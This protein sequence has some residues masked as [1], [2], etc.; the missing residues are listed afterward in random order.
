MSTLSGR[1]EKPFLDKLKDFSGKAP[2]FPLPNVVFY[3]KTFL[4]LHVFEPRYRTM[5]ADVEKTERLI[6]IVLLHPDSGPKD[7]GP[8]TP[9]RPPVYTMGTLGYMDFK[10]T[11]DDGTSDILLVGLAKAAIKEI[12]SDKPYRIGELA[13]VTDGLGDSDIRALQKKIFHQFE[14]LANDERI[15]SLSRYL[16]EGL[17]FEMAVNFIAAHTPMQMKEKQ[18]LLE[19]NDLSLRA[20]VLLQFLESEFRHLEDGADLG[21]AFPGDPRMN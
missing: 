1:P 10:K 20:K 17:D 12:K 15:S 6:C 7:S 16:R 8:E 3:P 19:L 13:L 9:G 4:P 2:L 14:R 21:P 18:K 5:V 11:Y